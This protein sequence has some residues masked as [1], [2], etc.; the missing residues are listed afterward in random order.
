ML[1]APQVL[2]LDE[3]TA[4]LDRDNARRVLAIIGGLN[5]TQGVT[6]VMVSHNAADVGGAPARVRL[7]GDR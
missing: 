3:P 6:I 2:L 1:L 4:A 5:R 7:G